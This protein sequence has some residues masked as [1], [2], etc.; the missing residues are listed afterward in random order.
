MNIAN[1]MHQLTCYNLW[2]N[3]KLTEVIKNLKPIELEKEITSSF[4]TIRKTVFHIWD[5]EY[6]WLK[7]LQ[8]ESLDS[9][10]SKN[11]DS[12]VAIE[13]FLD[14]SQEWVNFTATKQDAFY[15]Q[16]CNYKNLALKDFSNS[17]SEI[18]QHCMNHSTY[19]RGQLVTMLRQLEKENIP[20]T[21]FINFLRK[22]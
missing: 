11:Y 19:H 8:G 6:I 14:C 1:K 12:S 16:A 4:P 21:D 18:L 17:T 13:K 22:E 9:F 3:S 2:A 15:E 10:P 20:S 7:R 5:A